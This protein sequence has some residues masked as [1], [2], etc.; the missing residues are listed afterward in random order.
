MDLRDK[1]VAVT[2]AGNGVGRELALR[3][4]S[5]GAKVACIDIDPNG[6]KE[7]LALAEGYP[8]RV[9]VFEADI[10]DGAMV[11]ALPGKI[12]EQFGAVD[13]LINNAGIIHPFLHVT[14]TGYGI[15]EKVMRVNFFGTLN[16]TKAFLPGLC[17][18]LEAYIVNMSSAGA[19]SPMP[20]ET[21]YGA[22]KAAVRLLTEG[23]RYELRQS[24]VRVMAVFPGGINT[25]IIRNSGVTVAS[26]IDQLRARLAFL[27]LT[28][29]KAAERIISGM[30]KNRTRRVLGIDAVAMDLL[31]RV[32]PRPAPR[33]LYGIIDKVLSQHVQSGSPVPQK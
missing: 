13:A 23:L 22:S 8:G 5:R 3:L 33:V 15:V 29:Q 28:P 6:L 9:S 7:T 30:E 20:G 21:V 2:G 11:E 17:T 19:L 18:R 31:S 4:L 32:S 16:M 27:L 10:A 1:V 14:E 26:S 25:D 24:G 12:E